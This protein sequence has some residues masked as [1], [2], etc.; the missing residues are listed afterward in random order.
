MADY[1]GTIDS[2]FKAYFAGAFLASPHK[3]GSKLY[4]AD[5]RY[6]IIAGL[7]QHVENIGFRKVVDQV[8]YNTVVCYEVDSP[9]LEYYYHEC[10][11][12]SATLE[13]EL[14]GNIPAHLFHHFTRG[15]L[16]Y[17]DVRLSK[18][19]VLELYPYD[20]SR[21]FD[22]LGSI[23]LDRSN[24]M[25]IEGN[26]LLDLLDYLYG[27]CTIYDIGNKDTYETL[28]VEVEGF[29]KKRTAEFE[30]S[31]LSPDAFAPWKTR[32]SDSGYDLY[33]I[34]LKKVTGNIYMYTTELQVKPPYGWYFDV[35]PRSSLH[36]KG[37]MLVNSVGIIDRTYRGPILAPLLK[38]DPDAP[39]LELPCRALQLIPRPIV[40][41]NPVEMESLDETQRGHGGIGSTG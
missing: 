16:D 24:K 1:F 28:C 9:M 26:Q 38:F 17:A 37:Y 30:Y 10:D 21:V 11:N 6:S 36:K 35:V 5:K 15:F 29:N 22:N 25:V 20:F 27:D 34:G 8:G 19:P 32:A 13:T 7:R 39:D 2:E 23:D 40:H 14:K 12:N 3:I 4:L 18:K 31:K 33:L 41:F